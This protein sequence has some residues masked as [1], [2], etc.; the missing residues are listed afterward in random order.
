MLNRTRVNKERCVL[1]HSFRVPSLHGTRSLSRA[2][3]WC[4]RRKSESEEYSTKSDKDKTKTKTKHLKAWNR[5]MVR[6]RNRDSLLRKEKHYYKWELA[7]ELGDKYT[8][9]SIRSL[10][11]LGYP[12]KAQCS[13]ICRLRSFF[14]HFLLSGAQ[15][16]EGFLI[17]Y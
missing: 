4:H 12:H 10:H 16:G 2:S 6:N 15:V 17:L 3:Q 9:K 8:P 14:W 13:C 7:R 1:A 11:D 5:D